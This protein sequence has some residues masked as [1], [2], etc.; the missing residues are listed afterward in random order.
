MGHPTLNY[1]SCSNAAGAHRM[2]YWS[3]GEASAA[4]LVL[5][6]HGLARQGRDFDVLA[7]DMVARSPHPLRV[8]CPDIVGRGKSDW[9]GDPSGYQLPTYATDILTLL[10]VLHVQAPVTRLDWIG[11]SMGGLIGM[12]VGGQPGLPLPA[13][14]SRLVLNDV[15]PVIEWSALQRIGAYLGQP[16]HFADEAQA[17]AGLWA[18]S[19]SFGPHTPEQWLSLTIPMLKPHPQGGFGLH[20]DP[21]IAEPIRTI[22]E[23]SVRQGEAAIWQ[24]YDQ[25]SARTLLVRGQQSDLLSPYTARSMGLRGPRAKL[26]EFPGVGHAPTFV[27]LDQRNAVFNF[28]FDS[29]TPER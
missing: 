5:C 6:V 25:I 28:L 14:L 19:A 29:E 20:Y 21:A 10:G 2:A 8:V 26:V 23:D 15:G 1:V 13:P 22:T 9:L 17:A 4:H 3:W 24:L 27:A 12:I 16:A 7:A 18:I 11:T